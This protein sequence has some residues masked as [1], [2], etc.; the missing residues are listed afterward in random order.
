[1]KAFQPEIIL[2]TRWS[3]RAIPIHHAPPATNQAKQHMWPETWQDRL[4]FTDLTGRGGGDEFIGHML[5]RSPG[6][7]FGA[8]GPTL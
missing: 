5:P 8:C 4:L 7:V 1:M 3:L 6:K 2:V